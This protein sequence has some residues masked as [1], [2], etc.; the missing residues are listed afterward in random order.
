MSVL[1]YDHD[2][3]V[4][5]SRVMQPLASVCIIND[6]VLLVQHSMGRVY[7]WLVARRMKVGLKSTMVESGALCVMTLLTT[8]MHQ[9][10]ATASALGQT[11]L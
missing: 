8:L 6:G 3:A 1:E 10:S 5:V 9:L 4:S 2:L 7:V 11:H